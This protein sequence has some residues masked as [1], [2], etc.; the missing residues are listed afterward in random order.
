MNTFVA[1][2]FLPCDI[3]LYDTTRTHFRESLRGCSPAEGTFWGTDVSPK[4]R[5][6]WR[7]STHVFRKR[8]LQIRCLGCM[9][10]GDCWMRILDVKRPA[11]ILAIHAIT[12]WYCSRKRIFF[13]LRNPDGTS[14]YNSVAPLFRRG[15]GGFNAAYLCSWF[16]SWYCLGVT[17]S[18]IL[19]ARIK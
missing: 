3:I 14:F 6:L 5:L 13:F 8:R 18:C 1:G 10:G 7:F 2:W 4:W 9:F 19:K 17:P 16:I 11:R 15:T 12:N